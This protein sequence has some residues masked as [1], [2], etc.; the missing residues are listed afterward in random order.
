MVEGNVI[1]VDSRLLSKNEV[2]AIGIENFQSLESQKPTAITLSEKAAVNNYG[3]LTITFSGT[4]STSGSS[5]TAKLIGNAEWSGFNILYSAENNPAVGKD[6]FGLTWFG[7][8]QCSSATIF[9][10]LKSGGSQTV[11]SAESVP[12]AGRVW[13]FNE[14]INNITD[15]D[16]VNNVD[17]NAT[18]YKA[19]MTGNSLTKKYLMA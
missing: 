2:E 1:I 8:F 18:L 7:D 19:N 13:Q 5:V 9:A 11:S 14:Y 4:H 10:S 3:K 17:L 15:V 6:F 16:Y 12:N